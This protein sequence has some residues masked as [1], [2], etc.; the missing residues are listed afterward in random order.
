MAV[1]KS[2]IAYE[3]IQARIADGSY[4]P[5]QRL[6]LAAI[7]EET[8]MSV[9]PVREALRRLEAEGV[10]S[11]ERN[12]GARVALVD[13]QEYLRTM[14]TI[15]IVEG[16][17]TALAAPFASEEQLRRASQIN[18]ELERCLDPFDPN[19]FA[20]LNHRFHDTLLES[21]PNPDLADFART[22]QVRLARVR[23]DAM[24]FT[25]EGARTSISEHD[26]L[27]RLIREREDP[28]L[29]EKL[30]RAHRMRTRAMFVAALHH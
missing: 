23:D 6:V 24:A 13:E 29:I 30:F 9:V 19:R 22:Q 10:V 12:I 27:V 5:G 26:E 8:S 11:F 17:A 3:W 15:A 7:A 2:Q 16:A 28:L 25:V 18:R 14:Q 20:D 1:G 21:C 4:A